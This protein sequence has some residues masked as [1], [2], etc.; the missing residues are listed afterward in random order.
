MLWDNPAMWNSCTRI[1]LDWTEGWPTSAPPLSDAA[2]N[3]ANQHAAEL[4]RAP[5][6]LP[7]TQRIYPAPPEFRRNNSKLRSTQLFNLAPHWALPH[8]H[9]VT[10]HPIELRRTLWSYPAPCWATPHTPV[11]SQQ[12]STKTSCPALSSILFST[13]TQTSR[14][15]GCRE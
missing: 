5:T 1:F 10:L 15:R 12:G 3:R 6:E 8:H 7:R 9:W 14:W 13:H 2:P 11:T 4:C